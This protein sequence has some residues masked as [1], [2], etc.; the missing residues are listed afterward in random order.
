MT[1]Y[2]LPSFL[3][4]RTSF[5]IRWLNAPPIRTRGGGVQMV[6]YGAP[7]W[8]CAITTPSSLT[9]EEVL[10]LKAWFDRLEGGLHTF[11][12]HD[13]ALPWPRAYPTGFASLSPFVGD[14]TLSAIAARTVTITGLPAGFQLAPGDY[15]GLV[16]DSR[17]SLHRIVA[18]ATASG[19]GVASNVAFV[20]PIDLSL[21][22]TSAAVELARPVAEFIPDPGMWQGDSVL[23]FV[24]GVAV[25][26]GGIQR[27]S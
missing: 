21:F 5:D 4:Y 23:R 18:A 12:A 27:I 8:E 11:L 16:E 24:P 1:A 22:S 10:A 20:P 6:A 14:A 17:Y 19:G 7:Y 13:E 26:F 9:T 2:A 3:T 25:T 15:F